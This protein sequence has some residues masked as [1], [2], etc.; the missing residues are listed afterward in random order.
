MWMKFKWPW[1]GMFILNWNGMATWNVM[2]C[3]WKE[4]DTGMMNKKATAA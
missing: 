3:K 2:N 4:N 1:S